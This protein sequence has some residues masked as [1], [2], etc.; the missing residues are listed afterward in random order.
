MKGVGTTSVKP[1]NLQ[2]YPAYKPSGVD[3]LGDVPDHWD[4]CKLHGD[5]LTGKTERNRPDVHLLSVVR[6]PRG[7]IRRD[8]TSKDENRNFIPDDTHQLQSTCALGSLP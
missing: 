2:P 5:V 8:V 3:W 6:E 4:K 7:V 1:S